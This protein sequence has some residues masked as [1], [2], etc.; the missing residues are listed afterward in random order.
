M[1]TKTT[2][3]GHENLRSTLINTMTNKTGS[4]SSVV[5]QSVRFRL[6]TGGQIATLSSISFFVVYLAYAVNPPKT[7]FSRELRKLPARFLVGPSVDAGRL[8]PAA[9]DLWRHQKIHS[10]LNKHRTTEQVPRRIRFASLA[11]V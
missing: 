11:A 3:L 8:E 2:A 9:A 1:T 4:G 10:R 7:D 5:S 6:E